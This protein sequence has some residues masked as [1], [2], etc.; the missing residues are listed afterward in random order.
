MWALV[1]FF[2]EIFPDVAEVIGG[3]CWQIIAL[4]CAGV[5]RNIK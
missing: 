2:L 5:M 1:A 3:V 4:I